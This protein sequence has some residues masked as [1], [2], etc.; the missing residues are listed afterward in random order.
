M[1]KV[2]ISI[3]I[4]NFLCIAILPVLIVVFFNM[5]NFID[6][7]ISIYNHQNKK[8][9]QLDL[10]EYIKGVVAAEMP[11]NFEIDALKAQAIAARTYTLKNSSN[12][13]ITTDSNKNQAWLAKEK[14]KEK[15]G[16]DYLFYWSK[17]SAAVEE[18]EGIGLFYK[19]K[20]INS[21][22]HSASGAYTEAAVAVWGNSVPYLQ[23]V[24]SNYEE[25][26]PYYKQQQKYLLLDLCRR[27]SI[28]AKAPL[29]IK[30]LKRSASGRVLKLL[31]GDKIF[32]GKE[33]RNKL[34]LS[35]TKFRVLKEG[36]DYIFITS[37]YGHGVGMSQYGANGMAKNGYNFIQILKHYYPGVEL[38][39]IW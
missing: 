37:G 35:S 19:G 8:T 29:T 32:T 26:S 16:K 15:W 2:I 20:L 4:F 12:G 3:L 1:K 10:E 21:V 11:A 30:I 18:T 13:I 14:L 34:K 27:L 31:I 24:A 38:K 36:D 33:V 39:S 9:M 5:F 7:K 17:V 23:S 22:Y 6:Y 28:N 25:T